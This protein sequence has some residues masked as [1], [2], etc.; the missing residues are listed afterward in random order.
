MPSHYS[1]P[2]ALALFSIAACNTT[3]IERRGE[4][5][6]VVPEP[7]DPTKPGSVVQINTV[8][9]GVTVDS[10]S[11]YQGVEVRLVKDGAPVTTPN[12]PI[13]TKR[14]ALVRV[15]ANKASNANIGK[16]TAKLHVTSAGKETVIT[17]GPKAIGAYIDSSLDSTFNFPID[18]AKITDDTEIL[19]ELMSAAESTDATLYPPKTPIPLNA[20][21]A[22]KLRVELVPVKYEADGSNRL[23][24]LGEASL[25]AYRDA[26]YSLYP[27]SDL[28]ITQHAP[29]EWAVGVHSDGNGWDD[30]LNAVMDMREK[31]TVDED[32]YYV[33]IFNPAATLDA[34]CTEGCVLGV[35]PASGLSSALDADMSLRTALVLGFQSDRSGATMAQE[36]AHAMGRMHAPCGY[37]AVL[38]KDFP[39]KDASIGTSGYDILTKSLVDAKNASDFMS[40][41]TPAWVSD[42]TW[43]GI[44][45]R[46][47]HVQQM[48][49]AGGHPSATDG[50]AP[51]SEFDFSQPFLTGDQ[52]A[53]TIQQ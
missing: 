21:N 2:A 53:W 24:D 35:A 17:D 8:A 27:I 26:L 14:D 37:P 23:P 51:M 29:L 40:Y 49:G 45:D 32:V 30:L 1:L 6:E 12:A 36:L 39:Y 28:E 9:G 3:T 43:K 48:M 33:G 16:V 50:F 46:M 15:H 25:E 41:C 31:E 22:P 19:V 5:T 18:A 38:D 4:P 7:T 52:I 47:L 13:I 34:Y 11:V 42:Y 10:I 44:S 20:V